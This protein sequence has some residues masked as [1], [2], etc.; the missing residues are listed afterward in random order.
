[1]GKA[2]CEPGWNWHPQPLPDYDLWYVVSGSGRMRLGEAVYS[3][4]KGTCM[5]LRP[6]DRPQAEQDVSDRLTVIFVHFRLNAEQADKH[7]A[8]KRIPPRYSLIEDTHEF[9]ELLNRVL[10]VSVSKE[11][12]KDAEF[13]CLMKLLFLQLYR[14][15]E[16]GAKP[17]AIPPR[18]R[19]AVTRAIG[20]IRR[21]GNVR[22]DHEQIAAHVGLSAKYLSA[23]FKK[24]TGV[25][26]KEYLTQVRLDRGMYL[27]TETSMNV[28]QVSEAL[29]YANI[30]LFSKQFKQRF[31]QPPSSYLMK[32]QPP[33]PTV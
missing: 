25:P 6:G 11:M 4:G 18:Q 22:I 14:T 15:R 31:G 26:L 7:F 19:R 23:L 24:C 17:S 20:F 29:G 21:E 27:L 32:S 5:L 33:Q 10:D 1:M 9:E 8:E 13:D 3:L 30:F 12:Y 2:R 16:S 28:S